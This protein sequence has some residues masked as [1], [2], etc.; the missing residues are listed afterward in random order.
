MCFKSWLQSNFDPNEL[1]ISESGVVVSGDVQ[2]N[3]IPYVRTLEMID[4]LVSI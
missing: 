2:S 3:K 4:A 1:G